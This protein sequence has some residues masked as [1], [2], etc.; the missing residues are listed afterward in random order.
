MKPTTIYLAE[1]Y[2]IRKILTLDR[3]NF[4]LIQSDY[5]KYLE[6]FP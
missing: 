2:K 4:N 6:L 5:F 1:R 3:R